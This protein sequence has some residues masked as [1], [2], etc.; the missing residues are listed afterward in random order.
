M[1]RIEEL[2]LKLADGLIAEPEIEEL[3]RLVA[4]D[5]EAARV[6][7]GILDVEASLRGGR[8]DLDVTRE[9]LERLQRLQAERIERGVMEQIRSQA[10]RSGKPDAAPRRPAP[11][12][13]TSR[14]LRR[15]SLVESRG[16]PSPVRQFAVWASIAAGFVGV[17]LAFTLFQ[18]DREERRQDHAAGRKPAPSVEVARHLAEKG[19]PAK[20]GIAPAAASQERVAPRQPSAPQAP[21]PKPVIAVSLDAKPAPGTVEGPAPSVVEGP[22][23][24]VAE[25]PPQAAQPPTPP[26]PQAVQNPPRQAVAVPRPEPALARVQSSGPNVLLERSGKKSPV[27]SGTDLRAGDILHAPMKGSA[28]VVY[29]DGTRLEAG[30]DAGLQLMD[31]PAQGTGT[32]ALAAAPADA[33]KLLFLRKGVLV[34][35]AAKQPEDRPMVVTTPHAEARVLGTLFTLTVGPSSTRLDVQ[36][37][38][39]RLTR[40]PDGAA[41]EVGA[42]RS[43]TA[44]VGVALTDKPIE[45]EPAAAGALLAE[46]FTD[47]RAAAVRWDTIKTGFPTALLGGKLEIDVSPRPPGEYQEDWHDAGGLYTKAAFRF[48]LRVSA[49]VEAPVAH[50]D[51]LPAIALRPPKGAKG[52][53]VWVGLRGGD[54]V[55]GTGAREK[56]ESAPGSA[57]WTRGVR[58]VVEVSAAD[59]PVR[60]LL[61][62]REVMRYRPARRLPDAFQIGFTG[63]AKPGVPK[64]AR[65][66]FDDVRVEPMKP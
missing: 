60:V 47:P 12:V 21:E 48:P 58:A 43:A 49:T 54:V 19:G 28:I 5:P 66:R 22:A 62:G 24:I 57:L 37:G 2:T 8:Q 34:V 65:I 41:V 46:D 40:R 39:V 20:E 13:R 53:V 29:E 1:T 52:A 42:G 55:A 23:P 30:P 63:N 27:A 10:A 14:L 7:L 61:D 33:G 25:A 18:P 51:L 64:D 16:R 17:V 45:A 15:P 3:D 50:E 38:R 36:E 26:A 11:S 44:A 35:A 59:G 6:H 32:S 4:A 56:E 9:T 31:R